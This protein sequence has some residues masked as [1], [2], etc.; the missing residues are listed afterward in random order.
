[1]KAKVIYNTWLGRVI[2]KLG[3]T[4]ITLGWFIFRKYGK[5]SIGEQLLNHESIHVRQQ[6]EMVFLLQWAWY[7]VE[8]LVRLAVYRS[9]DKAYRNISFEREA[10]ANE[11]NLEYLRTRKRWAWVKYLKAI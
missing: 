2:G 11:H 3:Y 8:Y 9:H 6:V 1:M 7:F 5:N 10:Y 4:A